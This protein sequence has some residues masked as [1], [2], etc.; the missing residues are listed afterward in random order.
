M[1]L[2]NEYFGDKV[3]W[4]NATDEKGQGAKPRQ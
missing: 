4:A 1:T 2:P 3:T